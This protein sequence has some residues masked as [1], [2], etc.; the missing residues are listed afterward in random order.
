MEESSKMGIHPAYFELTS[1]LFL[2][3]AHAT[4][5]LIARAARPAAAHQVSM[6]S[7]DL[8]PFVVFMH[9]AILPFCSA[10]NTGQT[11]KAAIIASTTRHRRASSCDDPQRGR[12]VAK[13]PRSGPH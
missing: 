10:S 3:G 1:G 11:R 7:V 4:K 9:S 6:A 13:R 5:R 12:G 2:P 8:Y